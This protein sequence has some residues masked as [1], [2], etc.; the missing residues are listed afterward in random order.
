MSGSRGNPLSH[1][2]VYAVQHT[3]FV[4]DG[5]PS[6][7]GDEGVDEQGL[8]LRSKRGLVTLHDF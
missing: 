7:G 6:E 2:G 8:N 5:T 1:D 3:K 4:S